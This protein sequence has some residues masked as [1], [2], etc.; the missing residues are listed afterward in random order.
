LL[1][2]LPLARLNRTATPRLRL[3]RIE[4]C[5]ADTEMDMS[6]YLR[7]DDNAV[8]R[9]KTI[10]GLE[11]ADV[12]RIDELTEAFFGFLLAQ[13]EAAALFGRRREL[14]EAKKL[15]REHLATMIAGDYAP[16]PIS[17]CA[18]DACTLPPASMCCSF[19]ARFTG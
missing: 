18:W 3:E 9:R 4:D 13:P 17:A 2:K 12:T 15:K 10:V 8:E 11:P 14:D 16:M 6:T 19:S 1:P 5:V 7:L